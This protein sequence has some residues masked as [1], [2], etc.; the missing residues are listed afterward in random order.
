[1]EALGA[2]VEVNGGQK[3]AEC[4]IKRYFGGSKGVALEIRQVW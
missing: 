4:Y 3:A 1:M 2:V